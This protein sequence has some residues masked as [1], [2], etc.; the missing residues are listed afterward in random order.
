MN[1]RTNQWATPGDTRGWLGLRLGLGLGRPCC[2]GRSSA[3]APATLL[4]YGGGLILRPWLAASTRSGAHRR[5]PPTA[6]FAAAPSPLTSRRSSRCCH[7]WRWYRRGLRRLPVPGPVAHSSL[8][9]SVL[10]RPLRLFSGCHVPT[11]RPKTYHN[12]R[13]TR[14]LRRRNSETLAR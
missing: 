9:G 4:R 8:T 11:S 7:Y 14:M 3:S 10:P 12:R 6:A 2:V 5:S 13:R 1:E